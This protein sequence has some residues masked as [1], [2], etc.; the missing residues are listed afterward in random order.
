[1]Q[2]PKVNT[3]VFKKPLPPSLE[4]WGQHDPEALPAGTRLHQAD[5]RQPVAGGTRPLKGG[6]GECC[7]VWWHQAE[8]PECPGALLGGLDQALWGSASAPA[9]VPLPGQLRAG[10]ALP[11]LPGLAGPLPPTQ[12][13]FRVGNIFPSVQAW[14]GPHCLRGLAPSTLGHPEASQCKCQWLLS[15]GGWAGAWPHDFLSPIHPPLPAGSRRPPA[16]H[17]HCREVTFPVSPRRT[18]PGCALCPA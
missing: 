8:S 4:F 14:W 6:I 11:E 5:P 2:C 15:H 13:F 17:A 12:S 9:R 1:M 3:S 7:R 16:G 10:L 18:A